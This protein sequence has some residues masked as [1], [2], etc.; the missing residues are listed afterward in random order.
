MDVDE[1]NRLPPEEAAPARAGSGKP[2]MDL[3]ARALAAY[4][5]TLTAEDFIQKGDKATGVRVLVKGRRL[6][7]ETASGN[8]LFSG[9][10]EER[11][12]CAFVEGYWYWKK[13]PVATEGQP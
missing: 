6:R 2:H 10:I 5:A 7:C 8:L 9:G 12:V 3:V 11:A 1:S 13:L 4:G